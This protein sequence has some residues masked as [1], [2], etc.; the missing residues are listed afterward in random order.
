MA[1]YRFRVSFEEDSDVYRDIEI[2]SEQTFEDFHRVLVKAFEFANQEMASFYM[3]DDNWRKGEEI[4]LEDMSDGDDKKVRIMSKS[5]IAD[6][7]ED[8]HQKMIYVYDFFNMWTFTIELMKI[9]PKEDSK[10]TYPFVAKSTGDVPKQFKGPQAIPLLTDEEE[11]EENHDQGRRKTS[12]ADEDEFGAEE[13]LDEDEFGD[14]IQ[15]FDEFSGG[16]SGGKED[17]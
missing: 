17:Y 1:A 3:S 4:T 6:F 14:D 15:D 10:Q 7:I 8:P 13:G 2:K 12:F 16:Q 9:I 11:E 5:I